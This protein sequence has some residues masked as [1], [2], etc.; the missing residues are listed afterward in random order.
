MIRTRTHEHITHSLQPYNSTVRL[1][2]LSNQFN[3]LHHHH[4]S[5]YPQ[6]TAD[7]APITP[8]AQ[9]TPSPDTPCAYGLLRGTRSSTRHD[10]DNEDGY[11]DEPSGSADGEGLIDEAPV[12]SPEPQIDDEA[13]TSPEPQIDPDAGGC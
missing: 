10:N 13:V 5:D 11:V 4:Y 7:L 1:L 9:S 3:L 6:A 8:S 12:T 2:V